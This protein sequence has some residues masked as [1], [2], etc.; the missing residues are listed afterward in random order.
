MCGKMYMS[1][2]HWQSACAHALSTAQGRCNDEAN[3]RTVSIVITDSCPECESDHLDL[4]VS[5][6]LAITRESWPAH[7][8][9][10]GDL[11]MKCQLPCTNPV[12][13]KHSA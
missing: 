8:I 4:Q 3:A 13:A 7:Q 12:H 5:M 6:R 2:L 11:T 1:G 10:T 9:Q